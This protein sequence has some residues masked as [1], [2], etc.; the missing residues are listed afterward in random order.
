MQDRLDFPIPPEPGMAVTFPDGAEAVVARV[1]IRL[2]DW[3]PGAHPA[4]VEVR[5]IA[6]DADRAEAAR[7]Y[8]TISLYA[9]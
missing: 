2:R 5:T 1:H 3:S 6:E 7:M 8:S 4:A 9:S